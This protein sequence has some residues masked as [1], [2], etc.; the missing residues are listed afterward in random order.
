MPTT[1]YAD[2]SAIAK[3]FIAE[4]ETEELRGWLGSLSELRLLSSALLPVELLRLPRLVHSASVPL[5]EGFLTNDMD[6]VEIIPPILD[7]ATTMPP[8]RIRTL[9]AMHLATRAG[10]RRLRERPAQL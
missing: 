9:D 2:T 6:I 1:V 5:A 8:P 4:A 7:D 3:L 10:S